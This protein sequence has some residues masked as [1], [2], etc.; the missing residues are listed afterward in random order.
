MLLRLAVAALGASA[1]LGGVA[2]AENAAP[3]VAQLRLPQR[4]VSVDAVVRVA[5]D[6][7]ISVERET[8]AALTLSPPNASGDWIPLSAISGLTVTPDTANAAYLLACTE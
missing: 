2:S 3:T 1:A 5:A 7:S 6:G 4:G 8:L